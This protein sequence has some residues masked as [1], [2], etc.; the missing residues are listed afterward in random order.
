M[1]ALSVFARRATLLV[2]RRT[3]PALGTQAVRV[4]A[5]T[6][7]PKNFA[8]EAPDGTSEALMDAELHEVEE[9][10]DHASEFEDPT[11]VE[12]LHDKQRDA[13]RTFAVDAP[14]GEADVIHQEDL[15]AV[16]DVID[17]AAHHED[18]EKVIRAHELEDAV[19]QK[20]MFERF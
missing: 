12:E 16:E 4:A 8:V 18:R 5:M 9:I 20:N 13:A 6:T 3:A 11:F 17:H 10:I 7:F 2:A 14:D 19:R 15:H 1:N